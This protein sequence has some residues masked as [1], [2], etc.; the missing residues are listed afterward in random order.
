[1][2]IDGNYGER[3]HARLGHLRESGAVAVAAPGPDG[4]SSSAAFLVRMSGNRNRTGTQLRVPADDQFNLNEKRDA[5][6]TLSSRAPFARRLLA[7]VGENK[8]PASD[9]SADLIRQMRAF[10]DSEIDRLI[11]DVWGS[12]RE[13]AADK[14]K[15]IAQYKALLARPADHEP[16]LALG[17]AVFAKTCSQCHKLFGTGG[18][19]GPELTC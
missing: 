18:S 11:S 10:K 7:A 2:T 13:T 5:L 12:V 16:D 3:L 6:N 1:M 17:R 19:V 14:A 4:T 15:L 9:L 8:V